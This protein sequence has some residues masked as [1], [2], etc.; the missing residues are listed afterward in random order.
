MHTPNAIRNLLLRIVILGAASLLP[1]VAA[2]EEI[3]PAAIAKEAGIP[4][5][6]SCTLC[7]TSNPGTAA[8]WPG[9]KFGFFMG[10]KGIVK[11]DAN[12][13]ATAFNA[14][15]ALAATDSTAAAGLQALKDGIDPDTGESLCGPTYGC[16]AH[17][18]KKAP[19]SDASSPIWIL[20]AAVA[21]SILRRRRKT[22]AR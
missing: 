13:V 16:G 2:A 21:G 17:V 5:T 11:G 1:A 6:P 14:Y 15:K 19:P 20:G 7:H 10:T 3:F 9:K 8:T 4:C 12:S 22:N 18:A